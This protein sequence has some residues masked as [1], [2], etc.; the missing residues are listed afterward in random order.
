[1]QK[2]NQILKRS[3]PREEMKPA[4]TAVIRRSASSLLRPPT[5]QAPAEAGGTE[6]PKGGGSRLSCCRADWE[7]ESRSAPILLSL[8][9]RSKRS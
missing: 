4:A 1:M 2:Q 7:Q 6:S 3:T 9:V 5:R 8:W